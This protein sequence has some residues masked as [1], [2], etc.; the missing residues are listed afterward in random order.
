MQ[1]TT[2]SVEIEGNSWG[3]DT[4]NGTYDECVAYC[5][6]Y[7]YKIDGVVARLAKILVEDGCVAE[8]LEIVEEL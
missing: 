3:D 6:E 8:T 5:K 7:D 4:F 2:W 1:E